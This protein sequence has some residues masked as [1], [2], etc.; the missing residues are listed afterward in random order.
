M[1]VVV[2]TVE[3]FETYGIETQV[4]AASIRHPLHITQAALVGADIATVP[5]D[6]LMKALKHP[7]TDI[8]VE[9]FMAD[10]KSIA[11]SS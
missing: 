4:I 9:R 7:L 11:A 3:I 5:Y 10:W 2:D 1:Q 8:G 6:V